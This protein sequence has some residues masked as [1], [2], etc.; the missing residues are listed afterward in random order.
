MLFVTRAFY[1]RT[2]GF[3]SFL[4]GGRSESEAESEAQ[5]E[6]DTTPNDVGRF[7]IGLGLCLGLGSVS[8]LLAGKLGS[9]LTAV[10]TSPLAN[11][12]SR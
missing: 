7:E 4:W 3:G 6:S 2:E 11:A 5:S 1:R 8:Y 10:S 9:I 12:S